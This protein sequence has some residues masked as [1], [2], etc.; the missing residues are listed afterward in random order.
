[1]LGQWANTLCESQL[2]PGLCRFPSPTLSSPLF[3]SAPYQIDKLVLEAVYLGD[4]SMAPRD[5]LTVTSTAQVGGRGGELVF[6][7]VSVGWK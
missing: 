5:Y 6:G 1:M 3:C 2:L 4:A 7:E